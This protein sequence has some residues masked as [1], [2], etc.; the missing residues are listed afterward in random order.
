MNYYLGLGFIIWM[1]F[2]T[3]NNMLEGE[4][5]LTAKIRGGRGENIFGFLSGGDSNLEMQ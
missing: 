3:L 4:R 2:Y 5:E 1:T